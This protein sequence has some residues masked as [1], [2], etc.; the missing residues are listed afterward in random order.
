L[1][2]QTVQHGS[3]VTREIREPK[4]IART[5]ECWEYACERSED[6]FDAGKIIEQYKIYFLQFTYGKP[7]AELRPTNPRHDDPELIE[8][9]NQSWKKHIV[10][11]FEAC[12]DTLMAVFSIFCDYLML[13]ELRVLWLKHKTQEV[14][15]K[16]YGGI[17]EVTPGGPVISFVLNSCRSAVSPLTLLYF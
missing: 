15:A 13:P 10:P 7:L 14:I 3:I 11:A 9:M 5:K 16:E 4:S 17:E 1:Y 8:A 12:G 6:F 2:N